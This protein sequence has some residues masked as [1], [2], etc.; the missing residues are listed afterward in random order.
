MSFKE[1]SVSFSLRKT[2]VTAA[3]CV[4]FTPAWAQQTSGAPSIPGQNKVGLHVYIRAGLKTHGP[5]QHDYP[6]FLADW[7]KLLTL[8]GAVVDGSYHAP[9]AAELEG[10]DVILIYK[11]DAGYLSDT[12]R[13]TLEAFVKRGG[14]IVSIHDSLCGPDPQYFADEFVGGAK[15]H[16]EVNYTLDAPIPYTIVD[17][18]SP[19]MKDMTDMTI[20]DEAFFSMSWAKDPKIHVLATAVI[21]GTPSAGAHKGEVVPQIWTY[22]HTLPGGSTARAFVW[23][24]GH[25]YT[26]FSNPQLQNMLLR[27]VAWAAK[28]PVDELVDYKAPPP[29][30]RQP[31]T[32][33]PTP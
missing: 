6:Q 16:N 8:H 24:Q 1:G 18:A 17:K 15:K 11:G 31:R 19:L 23:M 4:S 5:G 9:T 12:E 28:R 33:P 10:T 25:N 14:G 7:S 3:L 32:V 26:N 13:A 2:L 30:P 20:E 27:G 21:A 29:P 22:E